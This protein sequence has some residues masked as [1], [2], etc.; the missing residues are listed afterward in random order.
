M[1]LKFAALLARDG[2]RHEDDCLWL[3][4][5][6]G[7]T[8]EILGVHDRVHIRTRPLVSKPGDVIALPLMDPG[9]LTETGE[10]VEL[11]ASLIRDPASAI[12]VVTS[13]DSGLP[14]TGP[15]RPS[16]GTN[17][18]PVEVSRSGA[19]PGASGAPPGLVVIDR[20]KTN[21]ETLQNEHL[22]VAVHY[23]HLA[24]AAFFP[25]PFSVEH[26]PEGIV[27]HAPSDIPGE[28]DRGGIRLGWIVN[29]R[30]G[31]SAGAAGT[32]LHIKAL[33]YL[34]L[35]SALVPGMGAGAALQITKWTSVPPLEATPLQ[36]ELLTEGLQVL[37]Q[38]IFWIPNWAGAP[39]PAEKGVPKHTLRKGEGHGDK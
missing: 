19:V 12:C 24:K 18:P 2:D 37:G 8:E 26:R 6:A 13:A 15:R 14:F 11:P 10:S 3:L 36:W 32:N 31:D 35:C 29:F 4:K 20:S 16:E 22:P 21:L 30:V 7:V 39:N 5:Q 27:L 9:T 38:V 34:A 25:T 1:L 28:L 33:Q 23:S 17:F